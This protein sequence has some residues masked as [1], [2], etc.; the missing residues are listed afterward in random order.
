M[1]HWLPAMTAWVLAEGLAWIGTAGL[2]PLSMTL[3]PNQLSVEEHVDRV[4][5]VG[6]GYQRGPTSSIRIRTYDMQTGDLLSEDL[7]DLNVVGDEPKESEPAGDRIFAGAVALGRAGLGD[8]PMR[9]YDAQSG[10][11]LWQGHLNFVDI[12]SDDP[13]RRAGTRS[14]R[15]GSEGTA[16]IVSA[17]PTADIEAHFL[18][19]AVDTE[20]GRAIWQQAFRSDPPMPEVIGGQRD[21]ESN[22][23]GTASR[24][25]EIVVRSY[26]RE[27]GRLVWSDRLST[28][29]RMDELA[30]DEAVDRAQVLPL[31]PVRGAED[32]VWVHETRPDQITRSRPS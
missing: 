2:V 23:V 11:Y 26:E 4:I 31:F 10:R 28:R 13:R 19:Q 29:D 27:T 16:R 9:V 20:S 22:A 12:G 21:A 6:F 3:P 15:I 1:T 30:D 14:Y 32:K 24:D 5:A 18:V 17:E 25:Y 7:F 8:F